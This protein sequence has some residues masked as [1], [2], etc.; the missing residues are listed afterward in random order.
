MGYT[1]GVS[2]GEWIICKPELSRKLQNHQLVAV[3]A[4]R[5]SI[6]RHNNMKKNEP[7]DFE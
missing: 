3:L 6:A 2:T 4:R 7:C 1:R 5:S